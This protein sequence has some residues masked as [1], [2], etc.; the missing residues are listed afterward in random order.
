MDIDTLPAGLFIG[1]AAAEAAAAHAGE[2]WK[3]RAYKA[4]VSYASTHSTF[5]T[6]EV[7]LASP[8]VEAPPELRAWGQIALRAKRAKVVE[9]D[10]WTFAKEKNVHGNAVTQ[11]KTI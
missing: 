7:R 5:T 10:G 6:E 1:H 3:E 8:Q 2:P 11:W 9:F 4:F